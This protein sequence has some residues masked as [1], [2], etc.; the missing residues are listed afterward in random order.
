MNTHTLTACQPETNGPSTF[1]FAQL[2]ASLP[3]AAFDEIG[4][5]L[6]AIVR[7]DRAGVHF[8]WPA[9]DRLAIWSGR[10]HAERGPGKPSPKL[11]ITVDMCRSNEGGAQPEKG[12]ESDGLV[13]YAA[14]PWQRFA[15]VTPTEQQGL[16]L[17]WQVMS[18]DQS[19]MDSRDSRGAPSLLRRPYL[20]RR[21]GADEW[22]VVRR[23]WI[24]CLETA[25]E[26][27]ASA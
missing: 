13:G 23:G 9:E 14:T 24:P 16:Y 10:K 20:L 15:G 4:R 21:H 6:V 27:G 11:V 7:S 1:S 8:R 12:G 25:D 18:W 26:E 2:A 17:L 5:P 19:R 3:P 22:E